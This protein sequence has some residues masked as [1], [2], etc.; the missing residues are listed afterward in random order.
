MVNQ[1]YIF[2]E[3]VE[4]K[5]HLTKKDLE[6]IFLRSYKVQGKLQDYPVSK[7]IDVLDRVGKLWKNPDY[8]GRKKAC[9]YVPDQVG[10]SRRMVE[11]ALDAIGGT[12]EKTYLER[13]LRL[14]VGR[15]E[16]LDG[17][18]YK[19]AYHG[20]LMAQP[21]GVVLH[22]SAGNVFIGG[23]DSLVHG[24]LTKNV[25]LLKV[26][27]ADPVFP[28][29]FANSLKECDPDGILSSSYAILSFRSGEAEI[30]EELKKRC[31]AIVVWGGK[32][33]VE[34]YRKNLPIDTKLIEYGPKYS[35]GVIT[36]KGF[37]G[38]EIRT[39]A[40]K[41]ALDVVMWE[42]RACSSPHVIYV[43]AEEKI[44]ELAEVLAEELENLSKVLPQ[45]KL[46]FDEKVEITKER[47]LARMRRIKGAGGFIYPRGRTDWTVT[48]DNTSRFTFSPLNRFI[49][50]KPFKNWAEMFSS[51]MEVCS[52]L[53]S[54]GI[55]ATPLELK[56]LSRAFVR[57]GATR[58]TE[59]GRMHS[60]KAGSPHEGSFQIN[61][62]VRWATIESVEERFDFGE[63]LVH[64][65]DKPLPWDKLKEI[66]SCAYENSEFYH[67]RFERIMLEK[68]DDLKKLPF[69]ERK[70][71]YENTP[72][73]GKG[74]LTGV[75]ENAYVF[76]SGGTTGAFKFS[77]YSYDE[78]DEVTSI[79]AEIY[80]VAGINSND[81][82][83]NL[84][85]A[86]N[87]WTSFIVA[88]E[89]LEKIGCVTLPIAG[90][91]DIDFI[92]NYIE[93]FK[94]TAVIGLPSIIIQLAEEIERRGEMQVKVDKILYG[95][96]H[97]SR[98]TTNYL[99]KVFSASVIRSAG[100]ASVDGGPIGYQCSYCAGSVH[101]LI[102]DYQYLEILDAET[103]KP[104]SGGTI[105]EIVITNLGRKLMP[106]IRYRTGD[107]GRRILGRCYCGVPSP[108]FELLGRCDDFLRVGSA[109]IN[110]DEIEK[111]LSK[112][113][114]ISHLFQMVAE[115]ENRKDTLKIFAEDKR[116]SSSERKELASQIEKYILEQNRE[117]AEAV[118]EGWLG[119]FSV[120]LVDSGAIPRIRRTGKIKKVVD[121][122]SG[123]IES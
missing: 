18:L 104:V 19:P 113:E 26:S 38:Q 54:V 120:E 93:V 72:P 13:K 17:W 106:V 24:F 103:G 67:Q 4:K 65:D 56:A 122:R 6:D 95:G 105:G 2:G 75:L 94:P 96:E 112:F 84:F 117:L 34:S 115:K 11:L 68:E 51:I 78:F 42:Q 52:Y 116:R 29:L 107:L 82:V 66:F 91:A 23:I 10:F 69:L 31:N 98:E 45:G 90:N 61:Q 57:Y 88:N 3:F 110:P 49:Y 109:D 27:S 118:R 55:L 14:E 35:F 5:G 92:L 44:K 77:F 73:R 15:K 71:I 58:I 43:E 40:K 97:L 28:L 21:H 81:V 64:E 83:A 86:G 50:L 32:E 36:R 89:A 39:V 111:A 123:G 16:Y 48:Y 33:A 108:L 8:I 59:I 25:N 47:E 70:D 20:Y 121:K 1:H 80:Q 9:R 119:D 30:E 7:I 102:S 22:V 87:L 76:A 46:T 74:L 62:M 37:D 101:H 85:M 114:G 41:L 60:G 79:L 12:M 53:Q 99:E 100:Y 63:R